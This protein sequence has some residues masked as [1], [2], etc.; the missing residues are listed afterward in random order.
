MESKRQAMDLVREYVSKKGLDAVI[1]VPTFMLGRYDYAPSS[2]EL[3]RQFIVRKMSFAS[4][5]GRNFVY[6]GDVAKAM[7]SALERGKK[8]ES[9]ILGGEN[10]S[11][12]DFFTM[13]AK[14]AG[15]APPKFHLPKPVV[16]MAGAAG[17]LLEKIS[18]KPAQLNLRMARLACMGTYYSAGKAQRELGMPCTPVA[19][20]IEESIQSLK[21]YGHI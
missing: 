18:G 20:A 8:G 3:I 9:Y 7:V 17:S 13:T 21:E 5:G 12:W 19:K 16:I 14:S 6:V 4:P 10:L 2:G 11:L 15:V 1:A